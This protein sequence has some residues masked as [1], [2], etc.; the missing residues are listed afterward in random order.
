[1]EQVYKYLTGMKFRQRVEA[2]IEKFND[3]RE[4]LDREREVYG[5]AVVEER[6]ADPGG[7]QLYGRNGGRP[8]GAVCPTPR[9]GSSSATVPAPCLGRSGCCYPRNDGM[10]LPGPAHTPVNGYVDL[11]SLL[12]WRGTLVNFLNRTVPSVRP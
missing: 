11:P 4:D 8:A 5:Q 9:R 1:M 10:P 3:M 7:C 6:G 2:V 12:K